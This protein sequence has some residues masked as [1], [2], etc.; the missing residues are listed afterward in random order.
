MSNERIAII[1][2]IHMS[3]NAAYS[4]FKDQQAV[5]LIKMLNN[6]AD[7]NQLDELVLLGDAFDLWLY[8]MNEPPCTFEEIIQYWSQY[9]PSGAKSTAKTVIDALKRCIKNLPKVYYINGNHDM[10]VTKE[11]AESISSGGKHLLWTTPQAYKKDDY[12]LHA[13]HGSGVDMFN[14]PDKNSDTLNGMPL[15]YYITRLVAT[16]TD[17]AEKW[18]K[19]ESMLHNFHKIHLLGAQQVTKTDQELGEILVHTIIDALM[20][21]LWIHGEHVH[22]NSEFVFAD[23]SQNVTIGQVKDSY[24]SLFGEWYTGDLEELLNNMLVCTR[25]N[26]LDWYAKKL[27]ESK[28]LLQVVVFGHTHHGEQENVNNGVYGNDG[29]W[30]NK[31]KDLDPKYIELDVTQKAITATLKKYS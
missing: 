18:Q 7:N 8:P 3:N 15:G 12:R 22:E 1:S 26:G 4:W 11:Q 20:A 24:H 21:D 13:E 14:A 10:L 2:D 25:Q 27:L 6:A 9:V 23:K 17:Q 5:V 19:L 16:A 31:T 30:C 29:C 28:P